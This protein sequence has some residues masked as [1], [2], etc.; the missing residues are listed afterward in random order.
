MISASQA[1]AKRKSVRAF[2]GTPVDIEIIKEIIVKASRAPS[3]GNL[4]P[5][6]VDIVAG[7]KLSQFLKIIEERLM[8]NDFDTAE[9][10]VYPEKIW[11]PLKTYRDKTGEDLYSVLGVK[12]EDGMGR[13]QQFRNNYLLFG[14]PLVIFFSLDK[15]CNQ[16]QWADLGMFMQNIMLLCVEYGL[17]SCPQEAWA[18]Y[19]KTIGEF[20]GFDENQMLYCGMAIGYKDEDAIMNQFVSDRAPFEAFAKVH[21]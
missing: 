17:D 6:L 12:R 16:P 20:L 2:K 18:V 4:Q 19:H 15:R 8:K 7:E 9:F 10:K 1:I 11:E 3:G 5:W 21:I 13:L 14:A